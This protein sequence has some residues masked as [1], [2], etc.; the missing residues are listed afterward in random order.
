[1]CK[2]ISGNS[3]IL[4]TYRNILCFHL[5]YE[6]YHWS[7]LKHDWRHRGDALRGDDPVPLPLTGFMSARK[8]QFLN[9]TCVCRK[10]S[11]A[12][13]LTI[14]E[15]AVPLTRLCYASR[16]RMHVLTCTEI[17]SIFT[18]ANKLHQILKGTEWAQTPLAVPSRS[19]NHLYGRSHVWQ[20]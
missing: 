6:K 11:R 5:K 15:W 10:G 20:H 17:S 3:V 13:G 8:Q 4:P 1:M 12:T 7:H 19:D 2:Q 16:V 14:P 18:R 9:I